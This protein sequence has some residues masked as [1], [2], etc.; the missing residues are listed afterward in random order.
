MTT[1][2][3]T[4][5]NYIRCIKPNDEKLPLTFWPV[6]ILDQVSHPRFILSL[7]SILII[8]LSLIS[9]NAAVSLKRFVSPALDIPLA[10]STRPSAF[11]ISWRAAWSA[12][13]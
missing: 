6:R 11:G 12:Y 10:R 8:L 9:S 5:P 4:E 1:I 2:E 3:A 13:F 7:L